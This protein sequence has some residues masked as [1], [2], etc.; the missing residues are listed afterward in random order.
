MSQKSKSIKTLCIAYYQCVWDLNEYIFLKKSTFCAMNVNEY[1]H[2]SLY[3]TC[4]ILLLRY[5]V[6]FLKN[7]KFVATLHQ[8]SLA[9]LFSQQH[10]YNLCL[11]ITF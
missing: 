4:F 2:T 7:S 11:C 10:L 5:Y 9:A 1:R 3:C 6:L 8:A